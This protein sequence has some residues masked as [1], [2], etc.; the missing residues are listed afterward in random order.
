MA[1]GG[2]TKKR[3]DKANHRKKSPSPARAIERCK[4]CANSH[5][6]SGMPKYLPAGLTQYVLNIFSKKSLRTTSLKTM[7]A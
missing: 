6:G 3:Y 5:D 4:P 2:E 7:L 1:G